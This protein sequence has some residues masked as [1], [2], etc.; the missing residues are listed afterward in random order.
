MTYRQTVL[1]G[2]YFSFKSDEVTGNLKDY[3]KELT[4]LAIGCERN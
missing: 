3:G 2:T 1:K 4:S